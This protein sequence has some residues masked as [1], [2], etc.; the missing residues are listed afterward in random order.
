MKMLYANNAIIL[1]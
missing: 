1:W